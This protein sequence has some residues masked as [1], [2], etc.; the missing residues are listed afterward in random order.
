MRSYLVLQ[1]NSKTADA[2]FYKTECGM[3]KLFSEIL[4]NKAL[5]EYKLI[6]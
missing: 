3:I 6:E 2:N 5:Y 1:I 4:N